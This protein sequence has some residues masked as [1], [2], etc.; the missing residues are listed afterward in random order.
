MAV[1]IK[2]IGNRDG[3]SYFVF[4][5]NQD[6][7]Q[8][9]N[10]L[11]HGISYDFIEQVE[12]MVYEDYNTTIKNTSIHKAEQNLKE[13]KIKDL[14]DKRYHFS[15]NGCN[16]D[17]IFGSKKVFVIGYMNEKIE[18]SVRKFVNKNSKFKE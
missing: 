18:K 7:L 16:I 8:F 17:I 1:I 9:L 14:I 10:K 11:I 15:C 5:K 13:K 6:I 2:S 4:Q 12:A 3:Y